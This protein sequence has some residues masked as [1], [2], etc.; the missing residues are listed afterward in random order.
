M[1]KQKIILASQSKRRSAILTACSIPHVVKPS[2][3]KEARLGGVKPE[4]IVIKNAKAKARAVAKNI[5]SGIVLGADTLVFFKGRLIG[6]PRNKDGAKKMLRAF[7]GKKI[8]VYSGLCLLDVDT[9]EETAGF[10]KTLL[11]IKEIPKKDIEKY[12]KLLGPYDKAGGF[13]IEGVGSI[14][15][16]DIQGSYFNVLGLPMGKLQGLFNKI[17]LDLLDFIQPNAKH[18]TCLPAGRR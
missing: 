10:D 6:K 17:Q 8:L 4:I 1:M 18:Y 5:N 13:S 2:R 15:F 7:S 3:V 9:G 16:D 12:F 14:V 11:R